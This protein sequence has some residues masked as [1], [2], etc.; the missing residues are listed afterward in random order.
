MV[1]YPL[2]MRKGPQWNSPSLV[3]REKKVWISWVVIFIRGLKLGLGTSRG[4]LLPRK[5]KPNTW[6]DRKPG[7]SGLRKWNRPRGRAVEKGEK[8]IGC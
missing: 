6:E 1:R 3:R 7:R 8:E 5:R 4:D 2:I